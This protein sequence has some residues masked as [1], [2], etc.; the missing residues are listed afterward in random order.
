MADPRPTCLALSTAL[1]VL[2]APAWADPTAEALWQYWQA[3]AVDA[4]RVL[5]ARTARREDG[6]LDLTEVELVQTV[7]ARRMTLGLERISLAPIADGGGVRVEV[8]PAQSLTVDLVPTEDSLGAPRRALVDLAGMPL[9]LAVTGPVERADYALAAPLWRA[10]LAE[11]TVDGV[12]LEASGALLAEAVRG[13]LA[14]DAATPQVIA[15]DLAADVVGLS[16]TGETAD[17]GPFQTEA[18]RTRLA[19][20]GRWDPGSLAD[21]PEARDWSL[22]LDAVSGPSS[23]RSEQSDPVTGTPLT[24]LSRDDAAEFVLALTSDR[25]SYGATLGGLATT[26]ESPALPVSPVEFALRSGDVTLSMPLA[27]DAA[28]QPARLLAEIDGLTVDDALW[29]LVDPEGALPR[30]PVEAVIDLGADLRIT[31]TAPLG[32]LLPDPDAAPI[33]LPE[34]LRINRLRLGY[35]EAEVNAEG[36]LTILTQGDDGPLPAP[37]PAGTIEVTGRGLLGLLQ[38]ATEAGI[39]APQQALGVQ[40][41]IGMF[42]RQGEGDE[43]T[44]RI[45]AEPDGGLLVNGTRLR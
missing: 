16:L 1:A 37:R 5:N 19:V 10:E 21:D 42:A 7:G 13:T 4:G 34:T 23:T 41:V 30:A 29:S 2:V 28:A 6:G 40:M 18:E 9:S 45:V 39:V 8:P 44:S 26:V 14:H 11:L 36:A 22:D 17:A 33:I 20:T 25:I 31:D 15:L 43:L 3:A 32:G 35:A 12:P 27:T 24:I 38:Q